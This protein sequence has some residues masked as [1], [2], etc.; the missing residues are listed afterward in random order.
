M[1]RD[2]L[3]DDRRGTATHEIGHAYLCAIFGM[4]MAKIS[5]YRSFLTNSYGGEVDTR[6]KSIW[7]E[8]DVDL[9]SMMYLGGQ[10]AQSLWIAQNY[11]YSMPEALAYTRHGSRS[12]LR[13]VRTLEPWNTMT[14]P[15]LRSKTE[16]LLLAN[17]EVILRLGV[18]LDERKRMGQ[19]PVKSAAR[20]T[21]HISGMAHREFETLDQPVPTSAA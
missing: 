3:I 15:Q 16:K 9:L 17:W 18:V 7:S 19:G 11:E 12:D 1:G 6:W 13:V 20:S 2:P 8:E 4:T 14:V 5:I 10:I 21:V